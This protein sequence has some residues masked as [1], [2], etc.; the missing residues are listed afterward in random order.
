[1]SRVSVSVARWTWMFKFKINNVSEEGGNEIE[2]GK[3]KQG[4][5]RW[6]MNKEIEREE[7]NEGRG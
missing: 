7:K 1:M 3:E 4:R 5:W 2:R 6:W